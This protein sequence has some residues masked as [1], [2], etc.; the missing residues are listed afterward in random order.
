VVAIAG[1]DNG[2]FGLKSDGRVV[3][4][5]TGEFVPG[6]SNAV[7][8][9]A[10]LA[11]QGDGSIVVFTGPLFPYQQY[12]PPSNAIAVAVGPGLLALTADGRVVQFSTPPTPVPSGL[13]NVV[14]ISGGYGNALALKDDGTVIGWG[15]ADIS[16]QIDNV[17]ALAAGGRYSLVLTTNPPPPM[18]AMVKNGDQCEVLAP[19]AVSGYVLECAE[20]LSQPFTPITVLTNATD[21]SG[22][23]MGLILPPEGR[24]KIFRLRKL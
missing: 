24:A 7:A 23:N 16:Q 5:D 4:L 22:P 15:R 8:I 11:L 1:S 12:N 9:A 21:L 3:S 17:S 13:S 2:G 18:L 6:V 19:V 14:A 10:G 20:D